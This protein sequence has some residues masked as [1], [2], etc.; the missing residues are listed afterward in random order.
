MRVFVYGAPGA[1]KTTLALMLAKRLGCPL[2]HLDPIFF[3]SGGA[4]RRRSD[5]L[6]E[7]ERIVQGDTWIIDGNHG[8]AIVPVASK[9]DRVVVLRVGRWRSLVR[10]LHRRFRVPV[11]LANL[12]PG[13]GRQ[14][15]PLHLLRYALVVHPRLEP[16]HIKKITQS[17][18]GVVRQYDDASHAVAWFPDA[19]DLADTD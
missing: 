19:G 5:A 1:G 2:H 3:F 8:A 4:P 17:T 13:G 15:L 18:L 14:V 9:A 11:A 6:I 10:L 16:Q 7:V 12:G